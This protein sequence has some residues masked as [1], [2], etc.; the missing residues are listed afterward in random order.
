MSP[1]AP[2]SPALV[3]LVYFDSPIDPSILADCQSILDEDERKRGLWFRDD[4]A[5]EQYVLAHAALRRLL[6]A[7]FASDPKHWRFATTHA[8]KPVIREPS[9]TGIHF[10]LSHTA[11]LV[12]CV[13][14]TQGPVGI[15][16][17][18]VRGGVN[19][20]EFRAILSD[21]ELAGLHSMHA[22][23][24][25]RHFVR[26]WTAKEA[27]A[28]AIGTGLTDSLRELSIADSTSAEM[29][30]SAT[31]ALAPVRLFCLPTRDG[32]TVTVAT[33]G[34]VPLIEVLSAAD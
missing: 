13:V 14:S 30:M 24:R 17:E 10:N 26:I 2:V 3:R 32:Y 16:A 19:V 12:A 34:A 20:S 25:D 8:G 6:S 9:H 11:G 28:K 23:D 7:Q 4:R 29:T 18:K 21:R 22:A 31:P 15:D 1:L 5:K 27:Y 33:S